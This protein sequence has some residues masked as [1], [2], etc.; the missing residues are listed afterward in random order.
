MESV[1]LIAGSE[2]LLGRKLVEK[3]LGRGNRVVA[4]VNSKKETAGSETSRENLMVIPWNRSSLFSAKTLVRESLRKWGAIDRAL[5]IDPILSG[6]VPFSE[7]TINEIDDL[8]D[9]E[10]KGYL[11]LTRE[12]INYFDRTQKSLLSFIRNKK[13]PLEGNAPEKACSSFFKAFADNLIAEKSE[14][15]FKLGFIN[16]TT[17]VDT[18]A[19]FIID[20]CDN[21]PEKSRGE[22]LR[23]TDKRSLFSSLPIEKRA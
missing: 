22:W 8:V 14:S 12:L 7:L 13:M 16:G 21:R 17:N 2:T 1:V 18:C 23:A 19:D 15:T 5:I 3:E 4:P 11:Y 9:R 20:I 6:G 10:I